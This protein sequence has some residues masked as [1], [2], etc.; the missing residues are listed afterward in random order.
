M[1]V[2]DLRAILATLP[3]EVDEDACEGW[4]HWHGGERLPNCSIMLPW[5]EYGPRFDAFW[6]ALQRC[7]ALDQTDYNN[8]PA[9]ADYL[10]GRKRIADAPRS[11]LGKWLFAVYRLGR[12]VEGSW[13]DQLRLG[14]L[15]EA[16]A[17]L[18]E[19][20]AKGE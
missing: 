19:L 3:E 17:R 2:E 8:W 18:A 7:G 20:E 10:S 16:I 6:A 15:K 13:A 1:S 11:D 4:F 12:F 9:L 14:R 5:C